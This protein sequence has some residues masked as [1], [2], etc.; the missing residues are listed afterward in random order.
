MAETIYPIGELPPLGEIP[1]KMYA[2]VI[3]SSRFGDPRLA[4]QVEEIDTPDLKPH[5]VLIATMAAGI[6]FNNVWAARGK[7]IDVIKGRQRKGSPHDFHIGG[8]DVSGII[9]AVGSEVTKWKV[10][11]AIVTHPG[12]WNIDDPWVLEGNDPMLAPS[13]NIWGYNINF[14][15][16]GQ[17]CVAQEHQ[18]MEKAKHLTWEEAAAPSLVGTTAYRMLYGWQGNELKSTDVVLVWGGSGGLGTQ[19]LELCKAAGARAVAV[20]SS[21]ERGKYCMEH[22]AAGYINRKD[23]DHWGVPPHWEDTAGQKEWMKGARAFGK[24]IWNVLGERKNPNIVFEHPGEATMAT[25]IFVCE[26]GGNVVVCAGTTGYTANV[27]LRYHW[28]RQKR[29]QGSH[30]TNDKQAYEYNKLVC[31]AKIDPC[32][33][34]LYSFGDIGLAH[35]EMEM[36]M[37]VMGNRV[38]LVGAREPGWGVNNEV[39]RQLSNEERIVKAANTFRTEVV[40]PNLEA[41]EASGQYPKEQMARAGELGLMGLYAP[42]A[43]GGQE[44][45]FRD[46]IPVYEEIGRAEGLFAFSMSMHNIVTYAAAGF[47]T[48]AFKEKWVPELAAGRKLAGFVLTEPQSGSDAGG[49]TTRAVINDDGSY[50]ITGRKAWVSLARVADVY[51]VVVKTSDKPGYKDMAMIAIPA[52]TPGISFGPEYNKIASP[53]MPNADMYLDNVTVPAE[54]VIL[55][56]GMGLSGSLFAIDIARTSIAAGCCGLMQA[57]L[58]IALSWARDRQMFGKS[59]FKNQGLRWSMA[60]VSTDLEASRLLYKSAAEK[61]GTPEGTV[62]AAHAKRFAPDAAVRNA[63]ACMQMLGGYGI[64]EDWGMGRLY[65]LAPIMKTVDGSTEIQ[66]I[67]IARALEKRAKDL[68]ALP[69]PGLNA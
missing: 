10:G 58:D 25:S 40:E 34:K 19:A 63:M 7:P 2:Q 44:L 28:V 65:R 41:W 31:D 66:R 16:F 15:S 21:D 55:P 29:L 9:Y 67:V 46:A 33:G 54:N 3:R 42:K 57:A 27:D 23:F 20:V 24:A 4:F 43:L 18:V 62:M 50:T 32:M 53:F 48:Q 13:A 5:E 35:Y 61:L 56:P 60:D 37:E 26:A 36:G 17:F 11:D 52:D 6:N 38:A 12:H 68:P 30:G 64:V 8:S 45:S 59:E 22:G 14:G 49:L 39:W 51:A 69:I 1:E 47:G